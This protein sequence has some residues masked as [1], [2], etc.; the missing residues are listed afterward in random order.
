MTEK[1]ASLLMWFVC[2][3]GLAAL[4]VW[5]YVNQHPVPAGWVLFVLLID[6]SVGKAPVGRVREEEP[7]P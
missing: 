5:L 2:L 4:S 6:Y 7:K 3:F 1:N